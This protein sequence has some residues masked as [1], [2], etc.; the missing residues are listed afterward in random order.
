MSR[1]PLAS[2]LALTLAG[3]FAACDDAHVGPSGG[4]GGGNA[5]GDPSSGGSTS[6]GGGS[7]TS[8][9][10]PC[11]AACDLGDAKCVGDTVVTCVD[12]ATGCPI[13]S[14]PEACPSGEPYCGGDGVC[15][16]TCEDTCDV[17]DVICTN[18]GEA[19]HCGVTQTPLGPCY[20][21]QSPESCESSNACLTGLCIDGTGCE[22]TPVTCDRPPMSECV[23][24]DTLRVWDST[25]LCDDGQCSYEQHDL[26]CPNCPSC[27]PCEG[28]TCDDPPSSCF[29][30]AG[31]CT[32]GSCSYGF[33]NGESCNDGDACTDDDSCDTGVC[34]GT[35]KTCTT[36]P[37]ATCVG[38]NTLRTYAS[39]G[40]CAGGTCS[41]SHTDDNCAAG[42]QAGACV[43]QWTPT[44]TAACPE[45]RHDHSVVW[46]GT[47]MIVWGGDGGQG[48]GNALL[49]TGGRYNPA[50]D[51]WT[52][53][54]LVGAPDARFRHTAVWT[55]AQM[56]VWGGYNANVPFLGGGRY[57]PATNTWS[58]MSGT[59]A[60]EASEYDRAIWTGSE[61]VVWGFYGAGR[62]NPGSDTW[63]SVTTTGA[64]SPRFSATVVWTGSEVIVWGGNAPPNNTPLNTG[65]RYHV[66]SNTWTNT[67][68]LGAP[69]A[70]GYHQAVWTGSEMIVW[71]GYGAGGQLLDTGG[72]YNPVTDTWTALP[73]TNAP[74]PRASTT[75]V[76]TGTHVTIWG[77]FVAGTWSNTGASFD[78][79]TSTWTPLTLTGAPSQRAAH[80]AV[81]TGSEMIVWGGL[82]PPAT[83]PNPPV[84]VFT[85]GRYLP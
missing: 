3:A 58:E 54:S 18:D 23:D 49:N 16:A 29:T 15:A 64:P 74:A 38:A 31:T 6:N 47:H 75:T 53:T 83:V 68:T 73:T 50:T 81:W 59:G 61:M 69:A 82:T 19:V 40:T 17:G 28:V 5:T 9:G 78:P 24:G 80:S 36:P 46:T 60:P 12:D 7:S 57:D 45:G 62:Y 2:L 84:S 1:Y 56:I 37:A 4:Q 25:G 20:R 44:S 27:D 10:G 35:P 79:V 32:G 34:A 21:W 26:D 51:S 65:G 14:Q 52:A 43:G 8:S 48:A 72:R 42:C 66:A 22:T 55:N 71:G 13:W 39:S 70:R 85:G 76:W 77:G 67:S 11:D 63:S 41:Y 30:A 33:A